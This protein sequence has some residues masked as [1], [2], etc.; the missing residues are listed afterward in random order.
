MKLAGI[1]SLLAWSALFLSCSLSS[2]E[3]TQPLP[4]T[5]QT[6]ALHAPGGGYWFN[7]TPSTLTLT[8]QIPQALAHLNFPVL[9]TGIG[10]GWRY[11]SPAGYSAN[12]ELIATAQL[13][14][15]M[16]DAVFKNTYVYDVYN[17][18]STVAKQVSINSLPGTALSKFELR[19]DYQ[20]PQAW[21][22]A[23]G[24]YSPRIR[25]IW[26]DITYKPNTCLI[27]PLSSP[28]CAGYAEALLN[29]QC[30][31]NPLVNLKCA[32]YE[33]A[34]QQQQC[35]LN[36]LWSTQC[37]GY[38]EALQAKNFADACNTNPQSSPQCTGY[39]LVVEVQPAVST[40]PVREAL[41][42]LVED[43][44]VQSALDATQV[45]QTIELQEPPRTRE[46][47]IK[48]ATQAKKPVATTEA[49]TNTPSRTSVV[50]RDQPSLPVTASETTFQ[51]Y[52]QA[53]LT[54]YMQVQL[55]DAAF[56]AAKQI[57]TT[58]TIKDNP[59]TLRQLSNRSQQLHRRLVD[60]Q[61]EKSR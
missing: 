54:Q 16:G 49:R 38:A 29:Q 41:P 40:D 36:T 26:A 44:T 6:P 61:Y 35:A 18:N 33:Q 10:Y 48:Q 37:A 2:A 9:V 11:F 30:A 8:S 31:A 27:D 39:V 50:T 60:E 32:G 57:Y 47:A 42:K 45:K 21:P 13:T 59:R 52:T 14:S 17:N 3:T 5:A 20:H 25:D 19:F 7:P 34:F 23:Y 43:A 22:G 53:N 12:P 15:T 51:D 46:Q 4:L 56:Y 24:N 58:N 28:N 55:P 1:K